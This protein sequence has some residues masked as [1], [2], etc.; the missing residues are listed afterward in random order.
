VTDLMTRVPTWACE[1][2]VRAGGDGRTIEGY[3]APWDT[4]IMAPDERGR[5]IRE[6]FRSG[7]F[8]RSFKQRGTRVPLTWYH[9]DPSSPFADQNIIGR[10]VDWTADGKGQRTAFRVVDTQRGDE[11]LTMVREGLVA[12]FSV[13]FSPVPA[14]TKVTRAA[15]GM[16]LHERREVNLQHV[17]LV[18]EGAYPGAGV[19]MVRAET[20]TPRMDAVRRRLAALS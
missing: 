14:R 2:V 11:A 17:A 8:D 10:A 20:G 6:V 16:L 1:L 12:A 15:D 19:D 3:I 13:G 4:E 5:P 7:A 9:P 18:P